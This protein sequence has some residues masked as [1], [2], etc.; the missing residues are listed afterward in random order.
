MSRENFSEERFRKLVDVA[1]DGVLLYADG[2]VVFANPA[3]ARL[4]GAS[5]PEELVGRP[6]ASLV[7][8]GSRA[9]VE[10]ERREGGGESPEDLIRRSFEFLLEREPKESILS[11]FH[12]SVIGRYFPDYEREISGM[13]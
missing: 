8:A 9:L 10:G 7:E 1:P 5:S 6:I 3:G 11:R 4:L 2:E 13:L 12:L